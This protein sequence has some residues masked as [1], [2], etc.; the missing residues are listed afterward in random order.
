MGEIDKCVK[1]FIRVDTVFAQLFS[2]GV[3]A[4]DTGKI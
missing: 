4:D 3:F 1:A 2:E